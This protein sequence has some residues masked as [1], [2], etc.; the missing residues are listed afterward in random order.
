[1]VLFKTSDRTLAQA[2][3]LCKAETGGLRIKS[4]CIGL[5]MS[6]CIEVAGIVYGMYIVGMEASVKRRY[7]VSKHRSI[8]ATARTKGVAG[9]SIVNVFTLSRSTALDSG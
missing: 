9:L 6:L 1:M 7:R 5:Q 4:Q 8:A 3:D 2:M